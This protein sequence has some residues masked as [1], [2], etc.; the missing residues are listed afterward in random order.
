[1]TKA[2]NVPSHDG[3]RAFVASDSILSASFLTK[4]VLTLYT[5][6]P[7]IRCRLHARG[8]NDTYRVETAGGETYYLRVYSAEWRH[9]TAI[10]TELCML[11]HLARQHAK[12]SAPIG[13]TD[14]QFYT[15]LD[16]VEG[17]RWAVLF[18]AAPGIELGRRGYAEELASRYGEAA[19]A[20][21][22]LANS[23]E[24]PSERPAI[25]LENLLRRPLRLVKSA[26]AHRTDDTD[27]LD[28]LGKRLERRIE[29]M[30]ELDIGFCHG[31]LHGANASESN[32][33][34]TFFDFDCCGWGYRAY[35]L[36]VFPW[37]FAYDECETQ[38]IEAMGRAFLRGYMR[39][40]PLD[41]RDVAA[42]PTFVAV[43]EIWLRGLHI[44]IGDRFGWGW[45][46]DWYYDHHLRVLRNWD[47]HFL[48][49][50]DAGWL[51]GTM[52]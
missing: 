1:M 2:S 28:D 43:R 41:E 39:R 52:A 42:I 29:E 6:E 49:H 17:R 36:A 24:G 25:N 51:L 20:I 26:I 22:A 44:D 18:A 10:Q 3:I 23:Y 5:L 30:A 47:T 15:P 19:A 46:N 7:I 40:R 45:M 9:P 34:F 50:R 27:Y 11:Q 13:R 12:V 4:H 14:G 48:G 35:D 16:C 38:R 32:G 21:H 31:D 8:L 37:G 33:S